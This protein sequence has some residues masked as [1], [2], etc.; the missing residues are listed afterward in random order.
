MAL[1]AGRASQHTGDRQRRDRRG[2]RP[3]VAAATRTIRVRGGRCHAS[4]TTPLVVAEQFGT[5]ATLFPDR[6]DLGSGRAPGTDMATARERCAAGSR[7]RPLLQDVQGAHRPSPATCSPTRRCSGAGTRVP[8]LDR[9][10]MAPSSPPISA[11]VMPSP[12]F[13]PRRCSKRRPWSTARPSGPPRIRRAALHDGDQRLRRFNRCR[14]GYLMSRCSRPS[15]G[16]RRPARPPPRPVA[17]IEAAD[18]C[19]RARD[20]PRGLSIS[21]VGALMTVARAL[22]ALIERC[23]LGRGDPTG[24][25]HDHAARPAFRDRCRLLRALTPPLPGGGG[26]VRRRTGIQLGRQPPGQR[27]AGGLAVRIIAVGDRP[28]PDP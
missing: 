20:G 27:R 15:P 10:S 2:D 25:I 9:A 21:A 14:R 11:R 12:A 1:L 23:S 17:D 8:D 28:P 19:I 7:G 5:L 16:P 26:S 13:C 4:R 24:Q 6:I 18:R 22:A 3:C